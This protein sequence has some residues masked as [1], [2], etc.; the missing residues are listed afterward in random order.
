MCSSDLAAGGTLV[1][2]NGADLLVGQ[3]GNDSLNGGAG[4]DVLVGNDA[5]GASLASK[6]PQASFSVGASGGDLYVF[7]VPEPALTGAAVLGLSLLIR[8]RRRR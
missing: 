8:S 7:Y 4:K 5:T 1:G 3:G 6:R 2:G